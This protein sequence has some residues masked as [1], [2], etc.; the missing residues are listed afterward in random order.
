MALPLCAV[1]RASG[2]PRGYADPWEA[3]GFAGA[4]PLGLIVPCAPPMLSGSSPET[5][6]ADIIGAGCEAVPSDAHLHCKW[7]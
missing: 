6:K 1:R 2:E 4:Q 5:A 7:G 3:G